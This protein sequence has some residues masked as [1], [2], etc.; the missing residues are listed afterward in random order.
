MYEKKKHVALSNMGRRGG[1]RSVIHKMQDGS[2]ER[3]MHWMTVRSSAARKRRALARNAE[4]PFWRDYTCP[5]PSCHHRWRG[6]G[7][8]PTAP[9]QCPKCG[10]RLASSWVRQREQANLRMYPDEMVQRE[11][12]THVSEPLSAAPVEIARELSMDDARRERKESEGVEKTAPDF[13]APV[14]GQGKTPSSSRLDR[15]VQA[16]TGHAE[17]CRCIACERFRKVLAK[18][19]S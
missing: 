12:K 2:F 6:K 16:Q 10:L 19:V 15:A 5:R 13:P 7:K 1:R 3:H 9:K 14:S 4:K 18:P 8:K 11:G 17:G